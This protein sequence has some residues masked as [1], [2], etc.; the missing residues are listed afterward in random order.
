MFNAA[1]KEFR[2]HSSFAKLNTNYPMSDMKF[3]PLGGMFKAFL[4]FS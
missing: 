3:Q 4:G 1:S 2:H